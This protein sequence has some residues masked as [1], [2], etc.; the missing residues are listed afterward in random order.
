M[1]RATYRVR[2]AG[3]SALLLTLVI[4][5]SFQVAQAQKGKPLNEQEVLE[6]LQ[7]GVASARVAE[8]VSE[9]GIAFEFTAQSEQRVRDSGG[10]NDVVTALKRAS[11]NRAETEQPR[12][13]GLRVQTTPG[14]AQVYLNDEP[15]GITSPEG[16]IRLPGLRPGSYTVRVSLP[17]YQSWENLITVTAGE[18]QSVYVTLVRKAVE[19]PIKSNPVPVPQPSPPNNVVPNGLSIPGLKSA[20]IQFY[21]GPHDKTPEKAQRVYRYSFDS[22]STRSIYWELD[23][24]FA[25]PGRK[26]D[27][28]VDAHWIRPDGSEMGKQSL[29]AYVE[30]TWGTSWHTLGWGWVDAGH[31]K[32]GTYRLD[33]YCGNARVATGTFQ[34]N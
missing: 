9:R 34:I 8:I 18:S 17:G 33:M 16:D 4:S 15:K 32:P 21:E 19:T 28:K 6:L 26:I 3:L 22:S 31:W 29:D 25:S 2:H 13:G 27:F 14:E 24:S 12:T 1:Q 23:L 30:A 11:A 5:M 20:T 10:A 7:G